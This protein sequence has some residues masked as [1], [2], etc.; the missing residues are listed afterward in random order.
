MQVPKRTTWN[1]FGSV[2]RGCCKAWSK[3][4]PWLVG[5]CINCQHL[6]SAESEFKT[7]HAW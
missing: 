4:I 1:K 6:Q 7:I 3:F 2:L 5:Y